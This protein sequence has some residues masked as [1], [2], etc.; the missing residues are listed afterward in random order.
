MTGPGSA[1]AHARGQELAPLRNGAAGEH[2]H[3]HLP[4]AH[5]AV[6]SAA[7]R[8]AQVPYTSG[9]EITRSTDE[10]SQRSQSLWVD[11]NARESIGEYRRSFWR[12]RKLTRRPSGNGCSD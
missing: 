10:S 7:G 6:A 4:R 2:R 1:A 12:A 8:S 3:L 5:R 9:Q 11:K